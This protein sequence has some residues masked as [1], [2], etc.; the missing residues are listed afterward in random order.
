MRVL[1]CQI[2]GRVISHDYLIDGL[3]PYQFTRYGSFKTVTIL[4]EMAETF[5]EAGASGKGQ[6]LHLLGRIMSL[7][8][9]FERDTK[10]SR[11]GFVL[12]NMTGYNIY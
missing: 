3:E 2:T 1:V 12:A 5:V 6:T 10:F 9:V 7:L 4:Q 11:V 8:C